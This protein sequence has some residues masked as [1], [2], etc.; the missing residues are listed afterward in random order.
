MNYYHLENKRY[1]KIKR[2]LK[3]MLRRAMMQIFDNEL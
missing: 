1:L 3:Q 2:K